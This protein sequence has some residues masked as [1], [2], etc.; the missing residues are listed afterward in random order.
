MTVCSSEYELVGPRNCESVCVPV[1]KTERVGLCEC[2]ISETARLRAC[3]LAGE[4]VDLE[5]LQ[6]PIQHASPIGL[7][8]IVLISYLN[9]EHLASQPLPI[10][11]SNVHSVIFLMFLLNFKI[12]DLFVSSSLMQQE[13]LVYLL[14]PLVVLCQ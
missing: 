11:Q 2:K 13:Y 9:K 8:K 10:Y 12:L 5:H 3:C 7:G 1:H 6:I 4:S 14:I